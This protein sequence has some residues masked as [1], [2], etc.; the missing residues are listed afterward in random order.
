MAD[1]NHGLLRA[2]LERIEPR[3]PTEADDLAATRRAVDAGDP[4][5]RTT[6]L[7]VTCSALVLHPPTRRVLLRWHP[8]QQAWLQVGGHADPGEVDPFAVACRE[9]V[10]ETGLT[11]LVAWPG[12]SPTLVHLALVPVPAAGTDP[13]HEHADL[14]YV[15][16]TARPDDAVAE[17]ADAPLQWLE[18]AEAQ[19]LTAE[20]NLRE[21]LA[22][23]AALL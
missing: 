16:A 14:R 8:R 7:H 11:D 12:D 5:S 18:L 19:T 22:R 4:W 20:D 9:A 17:S 1:G 15:L 6:P 21:T 23:I 2:A 13:A 10:E 3:S